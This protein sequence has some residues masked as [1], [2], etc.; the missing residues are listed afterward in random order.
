MFLSRTGDGEE[1]TEVKAGLPMERTKGDSGPVRCAR[2][3]L[4]L[5][6]HDG[7]GMRRYCMGF[8]PYRQPPSNVSLLFLI[9]LHN[10][11]VIC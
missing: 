6:A 9:Q 8:F 10:I 4:S 5:F 1:D 3:F 11:P 7:G 2:S